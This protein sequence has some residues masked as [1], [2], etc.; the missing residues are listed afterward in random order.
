MQY[1]EWYNGSRPHSRLNKKTPDEAYAVMLP[2]V[3]HDEYW[4]LL[5]MQEEFG[6]DS[7]PIQTA[8]PPTSNS[9]GPI[10][11]AAA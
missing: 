3:G 8:A 7:P 5:D 6:G 4:S 1:F 11:G 10:L 9:S 2:I